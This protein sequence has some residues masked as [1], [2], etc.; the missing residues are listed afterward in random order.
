MSKPSSLPS[1]SKPALCRL[2]L[3]QGMFG[4]IQT[5]HRLA[6][7]SMVFA[8]ADQPVSRYIEATARE[9]QFAL[10]CYRDRLLSRSEAVQALVL[11]I[12][13]PQPAIGNQQTA[14]TVLLHATAHIE[15]LGQKLYRL[16]ALTP[17]H[18]RRAASHALCCAITLRVAANTDSCGSAFPEC[19]SVSSWA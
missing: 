7:P 15:R 18:D 16:L 13:E 2:V 14:A 17:A 1:A 11:E 19:P 12:A 10:G 5:V 9:A 6:G 8:D 3:S 4:C